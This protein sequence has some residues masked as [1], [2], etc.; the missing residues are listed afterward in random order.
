M[1]PLYVGRSDSN[2]VFKVGRVGYEQGDDPGGAYTGRL[3]SG[4]ISPLGPTGY[5]KFRR[6][7]IR[8]RHTSSFTMTLQMYVDGTQTQIYDSSSALV[9]QTVVFVQAAPARSPTETILQCDLTG[10]GTY[11]EAEILVDSDDVQ[12]VFLPELVEVHYQPLRKARQG[13]AESQ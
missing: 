8:I 10:D 1:Y 2:T 12:G 6:V 11:I 9:D 4:R 3:L 13:D 5:V 7:A